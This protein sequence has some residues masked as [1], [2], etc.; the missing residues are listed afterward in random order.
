MKIVKVD[1][2]QNKEKGQGE[3]R[4]YHGEGSVYK[5]VT[6]GLTEGWTGGK[7]NALFRPLKVSSR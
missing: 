3:M 2:T 5:E 7:I 4:V 1:E 6:L